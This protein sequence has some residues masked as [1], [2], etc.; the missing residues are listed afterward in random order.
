MLPKRCATNALV[1]PSR[2]FEITPIGTFIATSFVSS[3]SM[4]G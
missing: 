3:A 2:L 1:K 4:P